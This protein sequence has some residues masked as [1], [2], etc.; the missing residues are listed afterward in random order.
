[1]FKIPSILLILPNELQ[2]DLCAKYDALEYNQ[3]MGIH[4][5]MH[6]AD[7]I[8]R[9]IPEELMKYAIKPLNI[10]DEDANKLQNKV[11]SLKKLSIDYLGMN[12]KK[13]FCS[14]EDFKNI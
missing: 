13:W 1:M 5:Y 11:R 2:K 9:E 3:N 7:D 4:G 6:D 8:K 14:E 12:I 10:D